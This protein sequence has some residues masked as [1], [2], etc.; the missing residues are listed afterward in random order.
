MSLLRWLPGA[1]GPPDTWRPRPDARAL[2]H[3]RVE[4]EE[5]DD[6]SLPLPWAVTACAQVL[7]RAAPERIRLP[8]AARIAGLSRVARSWLDPDD[9]SRVE[10]LAVL[11]DEL[12]LS[13][14]M[15]AWGLDRAFEVITA[16][17]LEAWWRRAGPKSEVPPGSTGHIWSGNVFVAGLPPVF[18]AVLAG[19]GALV[20]AP[21][22]H[23]TF[24]ALLARSFAL[25]AP[26]LGPSVG[27]AAWGRDDARSTDALLALDPVF[28]F[29]DD[30]TIAALGGRASGALHGFGHRVSAA[31]VTDELDDAGLLGLWED[32]LAYDGGGCLTPRWVF[33]LGDGRALAERLAQVGDAAAA[34]LP[35]R[36]LS[37]VEAARRAQYVGAA[38][39]GGWAQAGRGWCVAVQP[40]IQPTPPPRTVCLVPVDGLPD[41][42]RL[43]EPLGSRLQGVAVDGIPST[44][45]REALAGSGLARICGVGE[46]QRPP[47]DWDHD[48]VDILGAMGSGQTRERQTERE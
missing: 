19:R 30:A 39:F 29:G 4:D 17:A 5:D 33:V 36:A 31:V 18:G 34:A 25:H 27:A 38:G 47:L 28:A 45:V 41:V 7:E 46:L 10:A 20:K 23:P 37:D 35:G 26:E 43:L 11:P 21:S 2:D 1:G 3:L 9:P 22:A 6:D 8:R 14:G 48:G 16:D 12:G 24:A 42:T 15:V 32:A 13:P 40:G 44:Q